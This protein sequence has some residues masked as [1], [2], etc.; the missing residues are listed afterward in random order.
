MS[1]QP[2]D[3]S[4]LT[5]RQ[6]AILEVI[7][8]HVDAHGYPPSVREIGDAVGLKSTSSVHAQLETLEGKGYLRRDP[9][10]PRAL[11]LGR[12]LELGLQLRPGASRNVPLVGEIAAGG[13]ILAEER[14]DAVYALPKELVGEG[15][16]F[17]L[18][19]RGES[20]IEAGVLDGD[21]VV[22]RE[23]ASVEQGEMCA[24]LIEGEAT[25]KF[26]RRTRTGDVFL[27][28]A[29]AA[30]EPIPIVPG[31]DARIMGKVVTVMRSVR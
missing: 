10:K 11:E 19:V 14:V 6:R 29:N 17:L 25:V 3:V 27:D 23:Q 12:D 31:Q 13:P 20:M 5:P 8:A 7:H 16:L 15:Q 28:P 4:D 2:R 26:F 21:L 24:V 9:T 18:R 22:V 1:E 30:Y